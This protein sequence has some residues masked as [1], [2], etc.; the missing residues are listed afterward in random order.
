[1][2]GTSDGS[3][4][5]VPEITGGERNFASS[6]APVE[7]ALSKAEGSSIGIC[8]EHTGLNAEC[9]AR[10]DSKSAAEASDADGALAHS[11][12]LDK[13]VSTDDAADSAAAYARFSTKQNLLDTGQESS[14]GDCDKKSD[15]SKGP[16]ASL[17]KPTEESTQPSSSGRPESAKPAKASRRKSQ[18]D[19]RALEREYLEGELDALGEKEQEEVTHLISLVPKKTLSAL[20]CT[21]I[22][23]SFCMTVACR[24]ACPRGR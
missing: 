6:A 16:D 2:L 11:S 20:L 21:V 5:Q 3:E 10:S 24:I 23:W 1:M 17:A 22:I 4:A 8:P 9:D 19:A 13:H 12:S 14:S 18:A 15:S 7:P